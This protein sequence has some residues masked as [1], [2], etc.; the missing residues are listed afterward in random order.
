MDA[1]SE[2]RQAVCSGERVEYYTA[3]KEKTGEIESAE[4][5]C[6]RE[7]VFRKDSPTGCR[8]RGE[9]DKHYTLDAVC[10]CLEHSKLATSGYI[11]ECHRRGIP[12]ISAVDRGALLESLRGEGEWAHDSVPVEVLGA[13]IATKKDSVI[14]K[15][16]GR[17][18]RVL[19]WK[20]SKSDFR[21]A[22]R[23]TKSKIDELLAAYS[24]GAASPIRDRRPTRTKHEQ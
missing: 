1:L 2:I 16:I 11:R 4:Y 18:Q 24:R 8:V 19:A 15:A 10:F 9:S 6:V 13:G 21:E 5:V 7:S 12:S 20:S 23:K 17:E 22:A 14:T 3:E